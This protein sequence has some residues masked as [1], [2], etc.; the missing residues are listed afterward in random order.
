MTDLKLCIFGDQ[1]CDLTSSWKELFQI[2]TNPVIEDFF[3][4][5][6]DAVRKEIWKLPVDVR[7]DIPRFTSFNDLILSSQSGGRRCLAIDTAVR[8]IYELAIFMR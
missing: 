7:N 4:K 8:C 3:E 1:T 6:Y 2:R 5:S